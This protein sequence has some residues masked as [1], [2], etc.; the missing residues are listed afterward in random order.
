MASLPIGQIEDFANSVSSPDYTPVVPD[1]SMLDLS[2]QFPSM[3]GGYIAM[4]PPLSADPSGMNVIATNPAVNP[5]PTGNWQGIA[6]QIM[7]L[8]AQGMR[9]FSAGSPSTAIP[10]ARRPLNTQTLFAAPGS[11]KTNWLVIGGVVVVGVAAL[12]AFSLL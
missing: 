12:F 8:A 9:T 7:G 5:N 4:G 1:T 3:P 2:G 11:S 6:S 10:P